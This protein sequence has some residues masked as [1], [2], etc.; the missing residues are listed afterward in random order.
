MR[1]RTKRLREQKWL[2]DIVISTVGLDW[3]LLRMGMATAPV[4]FEA[5]GDWSQVVA[6]AK[7][8]DE[9]TPS[10]T[11]IAAL[12]EMRAREA[13][14][15][16]DE[17]TAR[18]SYLVASIYYG[19]AQW[20]IDEVSEQNLALNAKKLE[21]YS[22]YAKRA[23]HKIERVEIKMGKNIIPAWLHT[24]AV[25]KPPY[26]IVI[27]VPGM[28]N[29]KETMVWAY[30]DKMIERG[31]AALAIDGP[32]QAEAL[33][34]G[35]R[36]TADNFS[37]AGRACIDWIDTRSDLDHDR[38]GVFGRSFGSYAGTVL[39]NAIA[40]RLRGAVVG[41]ACFE[42]GFYRIFEEGSPTFK[43]RFMMM[44]GYDD[45][46]E[47]DKF[48]ANFDLRTRVSNLKCPYMVLGGELDELAP[49]QY[50]FEVAKKVPG[51]VQI[52]AYQ[53]E[54]HAPGRAQSAQLGPHWYS[55]MADWLTARVRDRAP[56]QR[57]RHLY[58]KSN[59]EVE[60]RPFPA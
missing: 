5:M 19:I 34:R 22:H 60:E 23:H 47:F 41:L 8:F 31:F 29:F 55:M 46:A 50:V 58:V 6:K 28:D 52:V 51:P 40:D 24:P 16:G 39:A 36:V 33:M 9:I 3:D 18:E 15:G 14:R 59:G 56:F 10:F 7:R 48:I 42:P 32:G 25:G 17:V 2:L 54:R 53:N 49:F 57:S 38:I 43:N 27:M 1:A 4:G 35:L 20:P 13:E 45:E 26:P 12:R 21:C 37:D 44:S 30:G 11:E